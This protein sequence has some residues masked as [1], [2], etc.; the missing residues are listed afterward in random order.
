MP[1]GEVKSRMKRLITLAAV[2][3]IMATMVVSL[4][5]VASAQ[6]T[7]YPGACANVKAEKEGALIATPGGREACA[8]GNPS[9]P[10]Q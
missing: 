1:R 9:G 5:G 6:A 8:P 10:P 4:A 2:V 7:F 3:L